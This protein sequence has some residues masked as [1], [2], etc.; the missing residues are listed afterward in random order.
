MVCGVCVCFM[1]CVVVL[2][3]VSGCC[4]CL[5]LLFSCLVS[6]ELLFV[7]FVQYYVFVVC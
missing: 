7:S 4:V 1:C 2:R 5:W 6:C 3:D